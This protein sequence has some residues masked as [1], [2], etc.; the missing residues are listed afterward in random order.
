MILCISVLSVVISPFSFLIL[1]ILFFYFFFF[2]FWW[3][4]LMI[5]LLYL[6]SQEP[7]FSF[8]DFCYSPACL[9]SFISALIFM[10]SFLL[11]TWGSSFLLFLVALGVKLGHLF[12]VSL[13]SWGKLV[14][15]W[16]FL[17]T[18]LLLNAMGLGCCV[19]IFIC[20]YAYFD[21]FFDFFCDL[22]VQERVVQPPHVGIFNS[23]SPVIEI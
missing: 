13:F 4:W 9:F 6:S 12:D 16:N 7:A 2:F 22:L 17:L 1:L 15:P 20:F 23:F 18:L 14:L 21:F 3:V 19:F 5:C 10:I 11:L 8:V